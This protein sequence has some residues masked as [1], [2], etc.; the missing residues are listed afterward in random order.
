MATEPLVAAP[1]GVDAD[2]WAAACAAVRAYCGWHIAPSVTEDVTVDGSGGNIQLLP[3]L[4]LTALTSIT[5]DGTAVTDPEWSEAGMVRGN[6]TQKLR[7]VTANM[8]HGFAVCPPELLPVLRA[9][10]NGSSLGGASSV[11][12]GTH[13]V[14]FE[15]ALSNTQHRATLDLYRMV[16]IA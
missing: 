8:T 1:A 3:T 7:G 6:W 12:S 9:I 14:Q 2:A 4:H 15:Q 11:T 13:Q 5:N 10:V 16:T